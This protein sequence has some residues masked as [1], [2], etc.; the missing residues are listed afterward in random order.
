MEF[1]DVTDLAHGHGFA[2]FDDAEYVTGIRRS[3]CAAYT[4]KQIDALTEFV[5]RPQVGAKGLIWIRV[6]ADA[7]KSSVDKFF[8]PDEVRAL[9]ERCG[10]KA[11]DMVF[12]LCGKKFRALT[13]PCAGV[14]RQLGCATR[15]SSPAGSWTSPMFER[16]RRDAAFLCHASTPFTS[17]K[18]GGRG[19]PG[20]T[21]AVCGP[22]RLRFRV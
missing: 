5:K 1:A 12:I 3:G 17:P 15:R 22:I 20:A 2:V 4:R 9:A 10:A 19:V 7:V 18:P 13:Q 6:E 21:R 14:A 16:G 11:G 8:T